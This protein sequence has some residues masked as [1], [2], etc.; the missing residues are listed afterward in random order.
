MRDRIGGQLESRNKYK[1]KYKKN[2]ASS[3]YK[4]LT[5]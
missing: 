1:E 4:E 5:L 2:P 3:R